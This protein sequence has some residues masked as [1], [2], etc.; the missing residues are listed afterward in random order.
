MA[1]LVATKLMLFSLSTAVLLSLLDLTNKSRT[2]KTIK[3]ES[4][5]M[6]ILKTTSI[7]SSYSMT[8]LVKTLAILLSLK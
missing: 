8:G 1:V 7:L 5:L 4:G 3:L 2:T 6:R